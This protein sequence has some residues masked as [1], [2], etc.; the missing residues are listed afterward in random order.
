METHRLLKKMVHY[1]YRKDSFFTINL[2]LNY[3]IYNIIKN[4]DPGCLI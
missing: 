2:R 3:I 1:Y 4:I